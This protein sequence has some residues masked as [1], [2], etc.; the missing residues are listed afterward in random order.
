[1]KFTNLS[2]L[3]LFCLL[4][5]LSAYFQQQVNYHIRV[6]LLPDLNR[7]EATERLTYHNRSPDTLRVLYFHLYM[8]KFKAGKKAGAGKQTEEGY[9]EIIFFRDSSGQELNYRV[10]GTV[11]KLFLNRALAPGDSQQFFIRFNTILPPADERFGYYGYH[12]DAGNWYP[13][14]AVYDAHGW[15]ADQHLNGEFYQEWG[16]YRVE[17]T[18]PS[19]FVVGATGLLQNPEAVPD[20]VEFADRRIDYYREYDTTTVTY[21]FLA[22]QVHDFAWSADPEFVVRKVKAG[23]TTLQFLILPYRLEEWEPLIEPVHRAFRLF[24]EKIGPYPYPCLTVV[25]GYIKAGGI[26]YPNLVIINDGIYDKQ[27]LLATIIHEIAHQW[28]YGLLANNQTRYGWMDE[29]FATF[30]ENLGMKHVRQYKPAYIHSPPGFW[31]KYFGYWEDA[32]Q[33]DLLTYLSYIR[34]GKEEPINR[35]FDWFQYN[36]YIPYYQKMSLVISQLQLLLG[37]TLFWEGIRQYYRDWRYRHPYPEDLFQAFEAVSGQKLNWFFDEWLN[38]T[39]H[40][41]YRVE[42]LRGRWRTDNRG[43]YYE[44]AIGFRRREPIVMPVDFRLYL[45]DGSRRDY[46]IPVDAG[47]EFVSN[48]SSAI[49]PWQFNRKFMRITLRLPHKV[50]RVQI[51]PDGR[52]LDIQP[53]N[54]DSRRLPRIHWY[55]MHRQYLSPHPD[56][57]TATIFPYLFYNRMDGVLAGFRTRGNFVESDYRHRS[58]VLVGLKSAQP[59]LHLWFEHPLYP[60]N[61]RIHLVTQLYRAC[62]RAGGGI[63]LQYRVRRRTDVW[64]ILFGGQARYLYERD[65][66]PFPASPGT[67]SYV[68]GLIKRSSWKGGYQPNGWEMML[69]AESTTFATDYEYRKWSAYARFRFPVAFQ[70][71]FTGQLFTGG[72]CGEAPLQKHFRPGGISG[73]LTFSHPYLR[74]RGTL[75]DSWWRNG[76]VF[77]EGGGNLR[78]LAGNWEQVSPFIFS[79]NGRLSLGNPLNLTLQYFPYLSDI[80]LS[81]FAGAASPAQSWGDFRN[82]YAEAGVSASFTRL[83]FLLSYFDADEIHLDFPLWVNRRV[84]KKEFDFRWTIRIDFRSFY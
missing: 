26:E 82:V 74:A 73:Y 80:V 71:K 72:T 61:P 43:R 41:D 15:H 28:F 44:A 3:L 14:P 29:G 50:K 5:S 22:R 84:D 54:N 68:E 39:W 20:S 11:L 81:A 47:S 40:C 10:K 19:G 18:V 31:G 64:Q 4:Q 1:M 6:Q 59:E 45:S 52:L 67:V 60:I 46:R 58:T 78:A 49:P 12:Y 34:Y 24:E 56:G 35:H 36:P 38:T 17:I 37:D 21:H 76:H 9:T 75:P 25:D 53:F 2:F 83:P 66:L 70:Q 62:G 77:A 79:A 42:K 8:N 65:Y 32:G 7:L 55:W 33:A 48:D 63:W 16:N 30:F 27:N 13:V 57:Y 69:H 23:S 51:D